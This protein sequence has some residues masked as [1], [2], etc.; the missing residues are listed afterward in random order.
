MLSFLPRWDY[1]WKCE[2]DTDVKIENYYHHD[3]ELLGFYKK[4]YIKTQSKKLYIARNQGFQF[5]WQTWS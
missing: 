5:I 2:C 1:Y 4:V 3:E